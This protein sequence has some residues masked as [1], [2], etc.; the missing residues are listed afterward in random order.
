MQ[1]IYHI[2]LEDQPLSSGEISRWLTGNKD[3][4]HYTPVNR[5]QVSPYSF[6]LR[7]VEG[8]ASWQGSSGSNRRFD[9][10]IKGDEFMFFFENS[11]SYA[12]ESGSVSHALCPSKGLLIPAQ[13]YSG[14]DIAENSSGEGFVLS[15]SALT[16]ALV[17]TYRR[18]VPSDFSFAPTMDLQTGPARRILALMHYFRDNVLSQSDLAVSPMAVASFQ[19][20]LCLLMVEN[21]KHSCSGFD[22][23]ASGVAP[24]QIKR[25]RDY[26]H[27]NAHRAITMVNIAE[28]AGVSV[29]ALQINFRRFLDTTPRLYLHLVRL[30]GV[31]CELQ[32]TAPSVTTVAEVARRWGFTH[33][34]RFSQEYQKRFGIKPSVDQGRA[35]L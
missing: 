6:S 12:V 34:G 26:I 4:H 18:P 15:R 35:R 31:R 17:N 30:D 29:R 22:Y 20:M 5:D 27:A 25:A 33:M 9:I 13:H 16:G 7:A 24:R 1:P 23:L 10:G 8:F 2:A 3:V 32:H 28:A 19:E 11:T 14:I 21:L